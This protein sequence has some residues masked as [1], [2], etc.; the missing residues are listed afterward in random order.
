MIEKD[1]AARMTLKITGA[2]DGTIP[3]REYLDMLDFLEA[4]GDDNL[5]DCR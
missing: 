1:E 5:D 2:L 4:V 3:L